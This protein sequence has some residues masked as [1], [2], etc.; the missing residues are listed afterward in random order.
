MRVRIRVKV[1]LRVGDRVRDRVEVRL[2]SMK[3]EF[4]SQKYLPAWVSTFVQKKEPT[5]TGLHW[6]KIPPLSSTRQDE[7]R[8][9]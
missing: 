7:T 9:E 4:R 1:R 3:S 8:Q 2:G 5:G 6:W